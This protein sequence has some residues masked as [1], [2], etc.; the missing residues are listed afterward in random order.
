MVGWNA[1]WPWGQV[2]GKRGAEGLPEWQVGSF[3]T[4]R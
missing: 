1:K 4:A 3:C 2:A